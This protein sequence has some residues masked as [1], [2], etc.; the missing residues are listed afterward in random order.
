MTAFREPRSPLPLFP[1]LCTCLACSS[2]SL[3]VPGPGPPNSHTPSSGQPAPP[4]CGSA[5]TLARRS[6][7]TRGKRSQSHGGPGPPH[8]LRTSQSRRSPAAVGPGAAAP[9]R[10]RSPCY[11][12]SNSP[13]YRVM[14]CCSCRR[15]C[16]RPW[17]PG[18]SP[19]F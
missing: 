16:R 3:P 19:H 13:R 17:C 2:L 10:A 14:C 4:G 5:P 18:S 9:A 12:L 1:A 11:A 15:R 7:T 6:G 8:W